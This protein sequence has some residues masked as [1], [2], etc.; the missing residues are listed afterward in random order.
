MRANVHIESTINGFYGRCRV[1][2]A[3]GKRE[4]YH[5]TPEIRAAESSSW[6]HGNVDAANE[7]FADDYVRYDLRPTAAAP[8]GAGQAK[9]AR[10]FRRAFP[11]LTFRVDLILA[12][13]DLV[14]ARWTA[15]G[16]HSGSWG[17]LETSGKR[18]RFLG[19]N[20]FR[21]QDGKV[22]E[23]WNHRDDLGLMQ[24]VWALIYAG[25]APNR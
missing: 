6:N 1:C 14:A 10:A 20:F 23:I 13:G 18:V 8:G 12:E 21:I 3:K 25:A 9:I 7:V 5:S 2:R 24:Q 17:G 16:T 19:V 11:D 22:A 15:E 4:R